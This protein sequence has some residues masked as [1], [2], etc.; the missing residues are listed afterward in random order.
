MM[1]LNRSH[2]IASIVAI[3]PLLCG[4]LSR[5]IEPKPG[6]V[7][8]D[9]PL[10][11]DWA[12]WGA[13]LGQICDGDRVD[14][15]RLLEDSRAIDRFFARV[16]LVG[17]RLTPGQFPDLNSRLAYAINCYNASIVQS[18]VHLASGE[19]VTGATPLD[20]EHRY[21]FRID[22]RLLCPADLRRE[23]DSFAGDDWRVRFAVCDGHLTG[24]AL[25]RRVILP[26]MLDAQLN[27][28]VRAAVASPRVVAV[29]HL[30]SKQLL[31]WHGLYEISGRLV[32]D[33]EKRVHTRDASILSVLLDWS[34]P[35]RRA[36]L[37]AAVGYEVAV[38]PDSGLINAVE[39]PTP[40]SERSVFSKLASFTLLS[41]AK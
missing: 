26:D 12:D 15:D 5:A 11:M 38:L 18:I 6:L 36:E 37:N 22:G 2:A 34:D 13:V 19:S 41:P 7:Q 16:A 14:Y 32:G 9:G 23:A 24:P 31:L 39:P 17:P 33:Y 28:L 29:S 30:L 1:E 25:S 21:R 20:L 8:A 40:E 10:K 35:D 27:E 3:L 4:C